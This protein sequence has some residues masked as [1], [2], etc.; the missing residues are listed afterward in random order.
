MLAFFGQAFLEAAFEDSTLW[1]CRL[2][3]RVCVAF[4][5]V[6]LLLRTHPANQRHRTWRAR[7]Q[8]SWSPHQLTFEHFIE[9]LQTKFCTYA[10]LPVNLGFEPE[11]PMFQLFRAETYIGCT[12]VSVQKR[13]DDC[14]SHSAKAMAAQI[15]FNSSGGFALPATEIGNPKAAARSASC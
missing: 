12:T 15:I 13:Q 1:E 3:F 4:A 2:F 10:L 5:V 11:S 6:S 14:W 7:L 9:R 8:K